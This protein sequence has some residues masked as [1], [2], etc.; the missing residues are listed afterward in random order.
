MSDEVTNSTL[1]AANSASCQI[2]FSPLGATLVAARNAK[3]LALKDVSNNLRLSVKQI[4]ALENDDFLSLPQPMITRGFIRN[5]ARLL[6]LDAEPLL[7]S[8]RT[9]VPED[10]PSALNV[11]TSSHQVLLSKN[12]QLKFKFFIAAVLAIFLALVWFLYSNYLPKLS[13]K[14]AENTTELVKSNPTNAVPEQILALPELAL[15][16]AERLPETDIAKSADVVAEVSTEANVLPTD[17]AAENSAQTQSASKEKEASVDFNTLK[18]NAARNSV[19]PTSTKAASNEPLTVNN[20]STS[21]SSAS[22]LKADNSISAVK[23]V[24]ISAS[25]QSWVRVTDKTGAV[26]FEKMLPANGEDG[27]N[28]LPPFKMLIGNAKA[29]KV[30]FLGQPVDLTTNTKSNVARVTLE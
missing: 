26:V 28:G 14:P 3:K 10:L 18:E 16:A 6:E 25:E 24:T 8:Y 15:P 5:Y 29:T 22:G 4:E 19:V 2:G 17:K 11:Q 12:S 30:N 7:A 13:V 9:R 1:E 21:N 23:S 27:F 20:S